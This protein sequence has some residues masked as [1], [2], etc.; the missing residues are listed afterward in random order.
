MQRF[1][2]SG[3]TEE[4]SRRA[5]FAAV[6]GAS[7]L[8]CANSLIG[9]ESPTWE[10]VHSQL[11][12]Y[13][14]LSSWEKPA[15][16]LSG[17]V[18]CGYQG[19]FTTAVDGAEKGWAHYQRNGRF[20]PGC[21]S[22]DLWPDVSELTADERFDTSFR[23]ADGTVAQVFSSHHSRTVA[24]HFAWMRDYGIDG[25]FVQRFAVETR[26]PLAQRHC[27]KVLDHCRAAANS[28]GRAY[29]LMYDLSGLA[30]G[31]TQDVISDWKRLVQCMH[32]GRDAKDR[33]YLRVK[34][35]PL[36]AVW[37][38]GFNDKRA[39]SLDECRSLLRF[40][41]DDSKYG[42]CTIMVGVPTF[43]RTLERDSVDDPRLHE[44][45]LDADI[46][47]PWSVGR[48][49]SEHAA[50][51]HGRRVWRPDIQWCRDHDKDYLPVA[52][53]GFSW[54]N[55]RPGSPL[56]QIP[57]NK[58][59]F[60][61]SQY[62]AAREAGLDQMYQAMFDELDEATAIFKV[63]QHPPVGASRFVAEPELPSDHYLWL[64]GQGGRLLRREI[65]AAPMPPSR[66]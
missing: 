38:I 36:V 39:Y 23:K 32:L 49:G 5:A 52:F 54:S 63:D 41:R 3:N 35:R 57:R 58:G 13:E 25:A 14:G 22:I 4:V 7:L 44:L 9:R 16:S 62:I 1:T 28:T 60:L 64:T 45:L 66:S 53:P 51:E 11:V 24:R 20:E 46:I 12:P 43:W 17:R 2:R 55:L 65:D 30:A 21:C 10:Q 37:G 6:A 19:W 59:R 15:S 61:W 40:L 27:N 56:G 26:S 47:S 42:G 18:V 34:G 48:F 33:A 31:Q 29:A 50:A 8:G